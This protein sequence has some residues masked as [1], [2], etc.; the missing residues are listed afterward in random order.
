[1][2]VVR[3]QRRFR[4]HR[5]VYRFLWCMLII[6]GTSSS[7][8]PY[9]V[10]QASNARRLH[11]WHDTSEIFTDMWKGAQAAFS[12]STVAYLLPTAAVI[13]G[14]SFADDTLQAAFRGNDEDDPL[15]RAGNIYG[16]LYFGPVQAGL[17]LTGILT[18]APRLVDTSKRAMAALL[19][20]QLLIQPLK[21]LT[22]RRTP[23]GTSRLSFP[24]GHAGAISSLIPALYTEYGVLPATLAT[25]SAGFIGFTR[26]Y[27][28]AHHLSD[29]LT[30]YAI[31][32]GWGLLV[33]LAHRRSWALLPLSEGQATV[34]LAFYM[35][36]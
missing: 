13:G 9:H 11:L 7:G 12:L 18:D 6:L 34:G 8:W 24:S 14:A 36:L 5:S 30:G 26:L 1:M 25:L 10:H 20:T 2:V 33:E 31:G 23:D 21:Y 3:Q 17:Y 16:L 29:V 32:F 35:R 19:G 27:G 28:N 22:R 4:S 15:A